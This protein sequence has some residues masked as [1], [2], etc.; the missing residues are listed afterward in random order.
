MKK[1]LLTLLLMFCVSASFA[2][3]QNGDTGKR[4]FYCEVKCYESGT[5][6]T[7]AVVFDFGDVVSRE[8]W[9]RASHKLKFVDENGKRIKFKSLVDAA[10]FLNE[11]GWTF[12][13][14]YSSEYGHKKS[15]KHWIFYKEADMT[16][17]V[18]EGFVTKDE[19]KEMNK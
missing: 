1:L 7:S 6:S 16:D 14:A 18:K 5:K 13:Q 17:K 11:R 3:L 10:H 12:Q 9:G 2:Q 8:I 19:Y 15:V 4:K